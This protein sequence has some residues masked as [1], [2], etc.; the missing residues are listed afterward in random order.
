MGWVSNGLPDLF[1]SYD[2]RAVWL[3]V[4]VV[5]FVALVTSLLA[6]APKK[7]RGGPPATP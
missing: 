5:G 2:E 1:P 4:L 7:V 3:S 6:Q